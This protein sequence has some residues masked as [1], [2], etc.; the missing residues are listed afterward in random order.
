MRRGESVS[1][2][3]SLLMVAMKRSVSGTI[4]GDLSQSVTTP[5][6]ARSS[7]SRIQSDQ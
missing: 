7:Q 5:D 3:L 6:E 4:V 2:V 1:V